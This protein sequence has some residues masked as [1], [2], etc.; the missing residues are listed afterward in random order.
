M[1]EPLSSKTGGAS[2]SCVCDEP[3][4]SPDA[5]TTPVSDMKLGALEDMEFTL[6][7]VHRLLGDHSELTPESPAS[8]P[9]AP[10]AQPHQ[11]PTQQKSFVR[12][13]HTVNPIAV[14]SIAVKPVALEPVSVASIAVE[15]MAMEPVLLESAPAQPEIV[16]SETE[17]TH[18]EEP[19]TAQPEQAAPADPVPVADQPPV[20]PPPVPPVEEPA[21]EQE[22]ID[23]PKKKK[24]K[25]K[26]EEKSLK[27]LV[28]DVVFYC[29]LIVVVAVVL[30]IRG[31]GEGP[32]T[33][34]GYSAFTV[35]SSS[36]QDEIPKGSLIITKHV[37]PNT[38]EIGDDITYMRDAS[39]TVTH[40]IVGIMENYNETGQRAFRTQGIMNAEPDSTPV[41][42]VN[43]VG[44]VVF[45]SLILGQIVEL[46]SA[47]WYLAVLFV[48]LFTGLYASLSKFV[49]GDRKS[50]QT[51]V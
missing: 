43:V 9:S 21:P 33:F 8:E 38:L 37:D 4:H 2:P 47:Y 36:M 1:D 11:E 28:G 7:E 22:Q 44:R 50:K 10:Q 34:A 12:K 16:P 32:T 49:F 23:T 35:L 40:R 19:A 51:P 29:A 26:K 5:H 42:A 18:L 13:P 48:L 6:R 15:P 30:M 41:V 3:G 25:A 24:K 45:H 31:K 39:S 46:I 27:S 20:E 14:E 17:E